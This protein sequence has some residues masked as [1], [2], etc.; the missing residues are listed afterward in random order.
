M[1]SKFI[2]LSILSFVFVVF[3]LY[4]HKRLLGFFVLSAKIKKLFTGALIV[5][6]LGFVALSFSAV[7]WS[8]RPFFAAVLGFMLFCVVFLQKMVKNAIIWRIY[9]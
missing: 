8:V 5:W 6:Q 2:F 7:Y 1:I 3:D 9:S 4:F